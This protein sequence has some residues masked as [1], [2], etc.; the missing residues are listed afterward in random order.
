MGNSLTGIGIE[1]EHKSPR[2]VKAGSCG[3]FPTPD[4]GFTHQTHRTTVRQVMEA[5]HLFQPLAG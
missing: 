1:E 2:V 3:F 5:R 4:A